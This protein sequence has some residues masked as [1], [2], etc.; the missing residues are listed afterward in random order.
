MFSLIVENKNKATLKL[1]QNESNYQ[2]IGLE[3]FQPPSATINTSEITN[4]DGSMYRSSYLNNRNVVLLVKIKGNVEE[5]RLRLYEFLGTNNY[6]KLFYS[7]N[8]RSVYCEGYVETTEN[9]LFSKSQTVQVSI[10]C[11]NPY[12]FELQKMLVD[13]S[14]TFANFEFPFEVEDTGV[15]LSV[16]QDFRETVVLNTGEVETGAE[17][18]LTVEN[19]TVRNPVIYNAATNEYLKLNTSISKGEVITINTNTGKKSIKKLADGIEQNIINTLAVGSTWHKLN[20]GAT[21][22]TF[23]ADTNEDNLRITFAYSN[24]YKGV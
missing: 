20:V 17:I 8:T 21:A 1:T 7:N 22:F 15:E 18:T 13:I 11:P 5:N 14:K 3:G 9:D 23:A 24:L 4:M 6:C 16:M 12:L 2:V 19:G 10:I